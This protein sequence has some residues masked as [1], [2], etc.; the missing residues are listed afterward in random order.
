MKLLVDKKAIAVSGIY[1][2]T[3]TVNGKIYI[4]SSK[5]CS[6]RYR[7][8]MKFFKNGNH[9][10]LHLRKAYEKYGLDAFLFEVIEEVIVSK[11]LEVEQTYLNSTKCTDDS[12]GYNL[13]KV[14]GKVTHTDEVRR[15]IS[16]ANRGRPKGTKGI[17]RSQ[18]V[19]DKIKATKQ[20][21]GVIKYSEESKQKMRDAYARNREKRLALLAEARA[22][23]AEKLS[24]K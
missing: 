24:L 16:E 21:K 5:D 10:N 9:P 12:I 4:G 7:E 19:K 22:K 11:L 8:H 2:I 17:P 13:E 3:N 15:K 20:A 23:K 6:R 14:A 1:K 18:E